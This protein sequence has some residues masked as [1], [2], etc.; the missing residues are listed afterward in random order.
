MRRGFQERRLVK[1]AMGR[2]CLLQP[3]A[4]TSR[5][6]KQHSEL[7]AATSRR[8]GRKRWRSQPR[9][10]CQWAKGENDGGSS[11]GAHVSGR[12]AKTMADPSAARNKS[13]NDER[14]WRNQQVSER[15]AKTMADPSAARKKS[16]P[17]RASQWANSENEG[18]SSRGARV[19]GREAKAMAEPASQ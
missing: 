10:A 7:N 18:R 11:G 2:G 9:R 8:T 15:K 14:R 17:R 4:G 16:E 19:N 3:A 5:S 1:A 12:K 13:E 6:A